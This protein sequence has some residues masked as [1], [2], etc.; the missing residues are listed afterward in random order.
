MF[1][2][3][4]K[5]QPILESERLLLRPFNLG[6][7]KLVQ[8]LAG[9][10]LI[11]STTLNIPHPYED[12]I[13]ESWI[14][15]HEEIFNQ[16]RG[17]T[18]AIIIK[19]SNRLIGAMSLM[20]MVEK[21]QAELGYWI[22]VPYWNN[23]YCTEAAEVLIRIGFEEIELHRIHACYLK[24]NPASGRVLKKLGMSHEGTRVD[25]VVKWGVFEDL[26]L[27]GLIRSEWQRN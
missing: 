26:E 25:H 1:Y 22:G 17:V 11:A 8:K 23:G 3:N 5:P 6:E 16:G 24:R 9:D 2:K 15:K 12:G 27:M 18:Y 13:A 21:H 4:M 20:N 14:S 19:E 10:R 7:A